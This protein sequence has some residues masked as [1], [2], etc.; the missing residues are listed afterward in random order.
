MS[1]HVGPVSDPCRTRVETPSRLRARALGGQSGAPVPASG[2]RPDVSRETSGRTNPQARRP[3]GALRP[4]AHMAARPCAKLVLGPCWIRAGSLSA[5]CRNRVRPRV[6]PCWKAPPA[7]PCRRRVKSASEPCEISCAAV[8]V[9]CWCGVGNAFSRVEAPRSDRVR[10]SDR[11][12]R[13]VHASLPRCR[14]NGLGREGMFHVK[15]SPR[16]QEGAGV[17]LAA[18][19]ATGRG[20]RRRAAQRG[21][22]RGSIAPRCSTRMDAPC[23]C[24]T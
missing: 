6:L 5:R 3:S 22:T 7:Q 15:H 24:F 2:Y 19:G 4:P 11:V 14:R 20:G 21:G 18:R 13:F 17:G 10:C 12:R 8:S 1:F 9:R 23:P 16:R